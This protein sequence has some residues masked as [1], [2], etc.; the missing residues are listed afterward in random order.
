MQQFLGLQDLLLSIQYRMYLHSH[1]I[2]YH[3]YHKHFYI[4]VTM[5]YDIYN[6]YQVVVVVFVTMQTLLSPLTLTIDRRLQKVR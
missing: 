5:D 2:F 4:L 1:G 3:M 6:F